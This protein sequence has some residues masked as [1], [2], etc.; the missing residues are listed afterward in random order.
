MGVPR[1]TQALFSSLCLRI[2]LSKN[3][4]KWAVPHCLCVGP[5]RGCF[6][7]TLEHLC[8]AGKRWPP[9]WGGET[10]APA[11]GPIRYGW[12]KPIAAE[13]ASRD[14][15]SWKAVFGGGYKCCRES[16]ASQQQDPPAKRLW[17]W[18][19]QHPQ[20]GHW[21]LSPSQRCR[22]RLW[23]VQG[24][25]AEQSA[26]NVEHKV[27]AFAVWIQPLLLVCFI[28]MCRHPIAVSH[29]EEG[30]IIH[31]WDWQWYVVGFGGVLGG[32]SCKFM[33]VHKLYFIPKLQPPSR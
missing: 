16:P 10:G 2:S 3:Q 20:R 23:D 12:N 17:R 24:Y 33:R 18:P 31:L 4:H 9:I 6:W 26:S 1:A 25:L 11:F 13:M 19:R 29:S 5:P 27:N 22:L 21:V 14:V 28:Q 30:Y 15:Y 32:N 8:E 7:P